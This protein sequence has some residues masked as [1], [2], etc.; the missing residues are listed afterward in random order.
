ML[1]EKLI[2][3]CEKDQVK[4]IRQLVEKGTDVNT[5]YKFH[6]PLI[7]A[8]YKGQLQSVRAL[9]EAGADVNQR[10]D[11]GPQS[12]TPLSLA[13]GI[14][15][16][17]YL[18]LLLKSGADVNQRDMYKPTPLMDLMQY[19]GRHE[20]VDLLINAGANVNEALIYAAELG[21]TDN[22]K[23]LLSAGAEIDHLDQYGITALTRTVQRCGW[24]PSES[25][26][27]AECA[28]F[29][30]EAGA[31]VNACGTSG[32]TA[33]YYV[34][35]TGD[36]TL[37]RALIKAGIDPHF[38]SKKLYDG[39]TVLM[40]A[41]IKGN[42]VFVNLLLEAGANVNDVSSSGSTALMLAATNCHHECVKPLIKAEVDVDEVDIEGNTVLIYAASRHS[43]ISVRLLLHAGAKVNIFNKMNQN[44]LKHHIMKCGTVNRET[45]RLL[46]AA[47]ETLDGATSAV[48]NTQ[49]QLINS[50]DYLEQQNTLKLVCREAIRKHLLVLD[51][52]EHLFHRVPKIGLPAVITSFMLFD[53][54]LD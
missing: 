43:V 48:P 12:D 14:N 6:A 20:C 39:E 5:T 11:V 1:S 52:H 53:L 46:V 34:V 19:D 18:D 49:N 44:A 8:M 15:K 24:A 16:P 17:E 7:T 30:T 23:K 25:L 22:V 47:G 35:D 28:R 3:A 10:V 13:G 4:R 50:A 45:I 27:H 36:E 41:V 37:L 42:N 51:P 9:I 38:V 21:K 54:S 26:Q 2:D 33:M 29:L 31:D 32:I 40:K